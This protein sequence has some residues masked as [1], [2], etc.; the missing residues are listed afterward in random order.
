MSQNN[1][2]ISVSSLRVDTLKEETLMLLKELGTRSVTIAEEVAS[3]RL[4]N[5]ISKFIDEETIYAAVEHIA[6][7]GIENLKLYYMFGFVG[8]SAEDIGAVVERIQK[9]SEIFRVTQKKYH[10]R[11]G[12]IKV[13][14]NLFNPKPFTPMQYFGLEDKESYDMKTKVLYKI[15]KIPN[16][17]LDIMPYFQGV[18]QAT[19]ARAGKNIH[20]FYSL[21]IDNQFDKKNALK[22]FDNKYIYTSYNYTDPL[23][24][25]GYFVPNTKREILDREYQKCLQAIKG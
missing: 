3:N 1:L 12:K 17:K 10:N 6:R 7:C 9:I 14:I 8:E 22:L 25:E 5:M 23:P 19:I 2:K 13:S 16:L 4:K 21:Y 18:L 20:E 15:K 24:W 11:L